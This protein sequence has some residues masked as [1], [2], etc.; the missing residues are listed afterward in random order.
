MSETHGQTAQSQQ[1]QGGNQG[2]GINM[3]GW[4]QPRL[5]TMV[6][7]GWDRCLTF[8]GY[9]HHKLTPIRRERASFG[10][11]LPYSVKFGNALNVH[12][13]GEM[14]WHPFSLRLT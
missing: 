11:S 8:Y 10:I 2:Q 3:Q 14:E 9:W 7:G 4:I 13:M 6:C 5:R 1:M 12:L